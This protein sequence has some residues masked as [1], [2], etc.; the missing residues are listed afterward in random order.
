MG[1]G[2]GSQ[3]ISN[4]FDPRNHES[5]AGRGGVTSTKVGCLPVC[6]IQLN[7][8]EDT[9]LDKFLMGAATN[10]IHIRFDNSNDPP[11]LGEIRIGVTYAREKQTGP[12]FATEMQAEATPVWFFPNINTEMNSNGEPHGG[13]QVGTHSIPRDAGSKL[14]VRVSDNKES[15]VIEDTSTS[16]IVYPEP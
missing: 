11:R 9:T 4:R 13:F 6:Y 2:G 15:C 10:G 12:A 14:M 16:E 7:G 3:Y 1:R 5:K 8:Q